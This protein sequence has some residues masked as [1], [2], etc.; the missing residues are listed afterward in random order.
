[1]KPPFSHGETTI[2]SRTGGFTTTEDLKKGRTSGSHGAVIIGAEQ[3]TDD[4]DESLVTWRNSPT[5]T[6]VQG[7]F[8]MGFHGIWSIGVFKIF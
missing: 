5:K 8:T 7:G 1:M 4:H 2:F 6:R 3:S